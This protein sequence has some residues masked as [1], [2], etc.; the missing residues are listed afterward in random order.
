M[1]AGAAQ[2]MQAMDQHL[3]DLVKRSMV[4]YETAV[5]LSHSVDEFSR[6][7]G[8]SIGVQY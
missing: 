2:G 7:A 1:Q 8:K 6:L 3:A 5:E 4:S